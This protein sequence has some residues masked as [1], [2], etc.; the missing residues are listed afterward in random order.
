MQRVPHRFTLF[1]REDQA[2][3]RITISSRTVFDVFARTKEFGSLPLLPGIY[4]LLAIVMVF[5]LDLWS[6]VILR[7]K[8]AT[9][10]IRTWIPT[11]HDRLIPVW[12]F[13]L[14]LI[15]EICLRIS[16]DF[17]HIAIYE[18]LR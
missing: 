13:K 18:F 11:G 16:S 1:V 7:D 12:V 4:G 14:F 10:V 2:D 15:D 9:R 5:W 8:Q 6:L 3:V 17:A